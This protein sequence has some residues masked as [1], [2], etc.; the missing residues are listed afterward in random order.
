MLHSAPVVPRLF[1]VKSQARVSGGVSLTRIRGRMRPRLPSSSVVSHRL[2]IFRNFG[3]GN[4]KMSPSWKINFPDADDD[5]AC[6]HRPTILGALW[7]RYLQ[8]DWASK[9][10]TQKNNSPT[11]QMGYDNSETTV[12]KLSA[13]RIQ[14]CVCHF[15]GIHFWPLFWDNFPNNVQTSLTHAELDS[16]RRNP[17]AKVSDPSEVPRFVGELI[18]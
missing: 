8:L 17:G 12:G 1:V 16:P 6:R 13:R 4:L 3:H 18:F 10:R 11:N 2:I 15:C 7:G 14:I 5:A 9:I